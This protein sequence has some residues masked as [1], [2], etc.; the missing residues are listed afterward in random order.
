MSNNVT[1]AIPV[2]FVP[3]STVSSPKSIYQ[4]LTLM[5]PQEP[6]TTPVP[7]PSPRVQT[8]PVTEYTTHTE[9]HIHR[10]RNY[11]IPT[12]ALDGVQESLQRGDG[13]AFLAQSEASLQRILDIRGPDYNA[14]SPL[15][16]KR[17]A[18]DVCIVLNPE[19]I[20]A[21][22]QPS[23]PPSFPVSP[24]S[25]TLMIPPRT[26]TP[27]PYPRS[28]TPSSPVIPPFTTHDPS[29]YVLP[30]SPRTPPTPPLLDT[31]YPSSALPS[32]QP[33][34]PRPT[35][36][37]DKQYVLDPPAK[38]SDLPGDTMYR[39]MLL[40]RTY[41]DT[42]P[43]TP[44]PPA[45]AGGPGYEERFYAHPDAEGPLVEDQLLH[46]NLAYLL[47]MAEGDCGMGMAHALHG[48]NDNG[49]R[50]DLIRWTD[51]RKC[52]TSLTALECHLG[53]LLRQ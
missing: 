39:I 1:S 24:S 19:Q 36:I 33:S 35:S 6:V 44:H 13:I 45:W 10:I 15:E 18:L 4:S 48:L 25:P 28:V 43:V 37:P 31:V 38:F 16:Q 46:P 51:W 17:R 22:P 52:I 49:I 11:H 2:T 8:N 3:S 23:S 14:L 34:S 41:P 5:L 30:P 20:H 21:L 26:L 40:L 50:G 29:S 47:D 53:E 32:P 12:Y 42:A 9:D 7:V 27:P